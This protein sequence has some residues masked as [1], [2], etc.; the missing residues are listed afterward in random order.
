M[1]SDDF[2]NEMFFF[3]FIVLL[4]YYGYTCL[5]RPCCKDDREYEVYFALKVRTK[6]ILFY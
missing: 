3:I 6:M 5:C 4:V 2:L 1:S